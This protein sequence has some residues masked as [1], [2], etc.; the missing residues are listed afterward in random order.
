[1][2]PSCNHN[3]A[4]LL[5]CQD[6]YENLIPESHV[7]YKINKEVDFSFVNEACRD[8]YSPDQGAPV[9]YLPE[10]MF[11]SAIIQYLNDYSDR[12]MEDAARYHLAI[13]WF[14]GLPIETSS[15]DH[16]ALGD[17]RVR[18]GD[19]RWKELFFMLLKTN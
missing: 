16:S 3:Q 17:F 6:I 1:M 9:K 13:N 10:T 2:V 19:E 15:F 5:Y 8:L 18:L 14:I 11:C 7:L 4:T 12:D